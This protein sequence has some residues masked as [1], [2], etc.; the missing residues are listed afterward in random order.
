MPPTFRPISTMAKRL[1]GSGYHLVRRY[2]SAQATLL[3]G[4]SPPHGKGHSNPHFLAH[5][6]GLHLHRPAFYPWPILSTRRQL[7]WQSYRNCHPPLVVKF[8]HLVF[9]KQFLSENVKLHFLC[10]I[11]WTCLCNCVMCLQHRLDI[12]RDENEAL[13]V[14]LQTTLTAKEDDIR[15][16]MDMMEEAKKAFI[17]G[18]QH[19]RRNSPQDWMSSNSQLL[20]PEFFSL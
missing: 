13:K 15:M 17:Q 14:A 5:C 4:D 2:D 12:Q 16:C 9:K 3:D 11:I 20:M 19:V 18:I 6:S 7:S 1:N 8:S 10:V